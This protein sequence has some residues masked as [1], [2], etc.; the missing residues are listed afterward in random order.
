[1]PT[2]TAEPKLTRD[3]KI[4]KAEQLGWRYAYG[5][6]IPPLYDTRGIPRGQ[7]PDWMVEAFC[8]RAKKDWNGK[9]A[10]E[11]GVKTKGHLG[12]IEHFKRFVSCI[13]NEKNP[14]L[15]FEWNPHAERIVDELFVPGRK[16][17]GIAGHKSSSKTETLAIICVALFLISP[18]N[19]KCIMTA[20]TLKAAKGRNW[21]RM[22]LAWNAAISFFGRGDHEVGEKLVPGVLLDGIIEFRNGSFRS[23][24]S[25]IEL[26]ASEQGGTKKAADKIVGA[27]QVDGVL[28]VN[29]EEL[30][31]L[32]HGIV[33]TCR[34]NL[35]VND[36]FLFAGPF[37][38]RDLYDGAM[39]VA[40]PKDGWESITVDDDGWETELGYCIHFDGLKSPNVTARE[41]D[42]MWKGLYSRK[43]LEWDEKTHYGQ[44]SSGFWQFV[45]GFWPP[46]GA[47]DCI[48]SGQEI[49]TYLGD[50]KPGK[51]WVWLE[52]P[53]KVAGLDPA[54]VGG[55]DR[56]AAYFGFCGL[57]SVLGQTKLVAS[58]DEYEILADDVT[59]GQDKPRQVAESYKMACE[60]RGIPIQNAGVD[61]TGAA[62]FASL[63]RMV[64]GEGFLEVNFAESASDAQI[65]DTDSRPAN[66]VYFNKRSE[67]WYSGKPLLRS[68]QLKGIGPDLASELCTCMFRVIGDKTCVEKKEDMKKRTGFS[69]DIAESALVMLQVC[70]ERLGLVSNERARKSPVESMSEDDYLKWVRQIQDCRNESL[71]FE[72][73]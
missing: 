9:L 64:W 51:E 47:L 65:A 5:S 4:A 26:V 42:R 29:A 21:G 18:H 72:W 68:G 49:V 34:D 20:K 13:W 14:V 73:P 69:P 57:A 11:E 24:T 59:K 16:F 3:E 60:T 33:E 22:I 25:G 54:Y 70:R 8:C 50:K 48:Y 27:K 37:N 12:F 43:D 6:L 52:P 1:M 53:Q 15:A 19:T 67:L 38:P 46:S 63:L 35:A 23:A 36:G 66:E 44:N 71:A 61:V 39:L 17:L 32:P 41:G 10:V 31:T 45:R 62:S 58:F 40:K 7:R 55:G 28:F 30:A 2:A 56:A